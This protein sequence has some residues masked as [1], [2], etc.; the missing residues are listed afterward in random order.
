MKAGRDW[1][2]AARD[3][4][5]DPE[6]EGED[7]LPAHTKAVASCRETLRAAHR[8][9]VSAVS[10]D[11]T[12]AQL[13]N[14][15][16]AV[17]VSD[18]PPS[19]RP[20]RAVLMGRTMAGK[21]TLLV[22]LTGSSEERIGIGAQRTS[23][24]VFAASAVDLRDVEIVDTPG[25]G[26]KDGAADVALAMAEVASADLVLW[27]A[28]NDSFQEETA[29][30]LRAV[31][32]RGKPVVVVL[33]CRAALVDD[34]DRDDFL[35]DPESVFDQHEGHFKTIRSHLSAAGVRP[36]AE[37]MLH[38][39]AAR[40][41]RTDV[42]HGAGL[43][44]ASRLNNL[45]AILEQ[46]SR[47]RRIARRVLRE[48]DEVRAQAQALS[49]AFGHVAEQTREI[50]YVGS[51]MREDQERRTAR[52]VDACKQRM[53]GDVS[54][55]VGQR[56]GWHQT[57]TDFGPQVPEMWENEQE[58]VIADLDEALQERLTHLSRA[59]DEA[60]VA[61]QREWT[62][63]VRPDLKIEGLR[64]FRG[65]WKRRAVG[66]FVGGGGALA[67]AV[68]GAKVGAMAGGSFG[69]PVGAGIGLVVG[70]LG[71]ALS[72]SLRKKS[73]SLFKGE[74]RI[75]EENR[76]LLRT[77]IGKVLGQVQDRALTEVNEAI[78]RISDDLAGAFAPRAESE[79]AALALA[80]VL[81]AQLQ[82]IAS[83]ICTLDRETVGC[84]LN[85]DGRPRL[86]GSVERATRLPGVCAAI[87]VTN[88]ALAE[89]WL[90]PPSSPEIL[91]FG[92]A[93]FPDVPGAS[94]MSYV[95]GLAE[96]VPVSIRCRPDGAVVATNAPVPEQ[97]LAAWSA[98]LS[99]HLGTPIEIVRPSAQRSA[100]T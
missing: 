96:E 18:A 29:Q 75:L 9:C 34:L 95:L 27:V 56:Q 10:R 74:A 46:E 52:L 1:S 77:E 14:V 83:A 70:G 30:A 55:L 65:L 37:V 12:A 67:A 49:E 2:P 86:A 21:S 98:T 61:A 88:A 76:E 63:A 20:M 33:N 84:L 15:L 19:A 57:I 39:E 40:Q 24:D 64:D 7:A 72:G 6:P 93:P 26:A 92:R 97:V 79:R 36:I 22:T 32:F 82:A 3:Q 23:Q 11:E 85:A 13:L 81:A 94:A 60:N 51:R 73:Q 68:I 71:A 100:F 28:S 58:A 54:R 47:E 53:E 38:A 5:F 43:R 4:L 90:F 78:A 50:V 69:G 31:A 59:I 44:E 66:V 8:L 80:D 25:V 45:L 87:Q 48:A 35:E 16:T 91:A 99:D 89:A 17:E 42:S 62:T 41:A